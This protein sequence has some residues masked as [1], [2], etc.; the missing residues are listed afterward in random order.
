MNN[1]NIHKKM[2]LIP[3][4]LFS[5]LFA[6]S[7]IFAKEKSVFILLENNVYN[8]LNENT[9]AKDFLRGLKNIRNSFTKGFTNSKE[10]WHAFRLLEN[11]IPTLSQLTHETLE[12][13]G[14]FH[15]FYQEKEMQTFLL[16][17]ISTKRSVKKSLKLPSLISSSEFKK[18]EEIQTWFSHLQRTRMNN[19]IEKFSSYPTR[20]YT[21]PSGIEAM[22]WLFE[23]WKKMGQGRNDIVV[24]KFVHKN[25][26][27][28]SIILTIKG[29]LDNG[30][31]L[32][33]GG[34]GDSINTDDGPQGHAPGADDNAAGI[35]LLT[36]LIQLIIEHNY[37][38]RHDLTFMAYAAEEVGILGS[39]EITRN[40]RQNNK[41]IAG[42]LQF[43]GINYQGETF[44]MALIEDLTN[45]EQNLFL[46][47]L[48]DEYIKVP[49]TYQRCGYACSDHAAWNYEGYPVSYPVET[50]ATEQNP[51]FHTAR[52][53]FDKSQ[54]DTLHAEKFLKLAI[55]FLLERDQI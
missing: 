28:P 44:E 9:E 7:L 31:S 16:K 51:H 24:E 6:T 29:S 22:N 41:A 27:Q 8:Q 4:T 25:F 55:A 47:K 34:H 18:S 37:K 54:Y 40:Y 15:T 14:G 20:Y 26:K 45:R 11:Q 1:F 10:K 3:L 13:C 5:Y 2:F 23:K 33:F 52:D 48:I 50:I 43:D 12:R 49:W 30:E 17:E 35:A 38:P 42:V 39:Y 19:F 46:A 53:T 21:S 36:E 32:V